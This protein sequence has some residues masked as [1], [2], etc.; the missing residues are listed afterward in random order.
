MQLQCSLR[1]AGVAACNEEHIEDEAQNV[2]SQGFS[3][4]GMITLNF[5][6]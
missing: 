4:S 2:N 1:S 5:L 3:S 6:E